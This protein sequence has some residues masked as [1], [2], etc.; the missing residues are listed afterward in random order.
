MVCP[1]L[2]PH[3]GFY[4]EL[5]LLKSPVWDEPKV[6]ILWVFFCGNT[7]ILIHRD[8][9]QP[10]KVHFLLGSSWSKHGNKVRVSVNET[11]LGLFRENSSSWTG[12]ISYL[13]LPDLFRCFF[14]PV[15]GNSQGKQHKQGWGEDPGKV[16]ECCVHHPGWVTPAQTHQSWL[17]TSATTDLIT[18]STLEL[19]KKKNRIKDC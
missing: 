17:Q 5:T 6:A 11:Q 16:L 19:K 7:G 3:S 12:K 9:A 15:S 4:R 13:E 8:V 14:L 2:S 1:E 10:M 18:P